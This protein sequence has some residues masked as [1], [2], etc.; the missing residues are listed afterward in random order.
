MSRFD[1]LWA[2]ARTEIPGMR[3]VSK[4]DS[5]FMSTIFAVLA[6]ITR[7]PRDSWDGFT[8][9]IWRTMY[10]PPGFAFWAI[11]DRYRLL[12]HELVHLRQFRR[13]PLPW[14]DRPGV[15]RINAVLMSLCY[16]LVLPVRW[17][18]RAK[19]EREAY[20]QSMLSWYEC[21][22]YGFT[23]HYKARQIAKMGQTF[24]SGTYAWMWTRAKAEQWAA[25]TLAAI[26][27]GDITNARDN[28]DGW[29]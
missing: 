12:R 21:R 9:T 18:F 22:H 29:E 24:G 10:V 2:L 5:S 25:D 19:F 16:L 4:D 14:L 28:V 17:T 20:T 3:L 6:F 27:R 1:E 26:E 23:S 7:R 15:W 11:E 8:T 13:W